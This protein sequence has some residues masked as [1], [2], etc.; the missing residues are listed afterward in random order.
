MVND[1][2]YPVFEAIVEAY[3]DKHGPPPPWWRPLRRRK[4]AIHAAGFLEGGA[5]MASVRGVMR[6]LATDAEEEDYN[7][8]GWYGMADMG[9]DEDLTP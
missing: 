4:Y 3:I 9:H 7:D 5:L 8:G 1:H 6:V 2:P